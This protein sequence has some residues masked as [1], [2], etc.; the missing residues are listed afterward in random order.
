MDFAP[1][2]LIRVIYSHNSFTTTAPVPTLTSLT[3]VI[4]QC[5]AVLPSAPTAIDGC[6][7]LITGTTTNTGPFGQGDFTIVWTFTDA[8]GN[9]STQNQAVHVHD[10]IAPLIKGVT[11]TPNTL[12][13]VNHKMALITVNYTATDNCGMGGTVLSATSN[14]PDNGTGDGDTTND[15]QLIPG[16]A[17]H[18]YLRAERS[19]K[20][21]GRVYTITITATDTHNNRSRAQVL[22]TVPH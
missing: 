13:S 17:H 11:A 6:G 1:A 15:I 5:E 2:D 10:T 4:A 3:D 9:S 14:E 7:T 18:L 21:H 19:G 16:N 22:V 8:A 20:G 12:Q